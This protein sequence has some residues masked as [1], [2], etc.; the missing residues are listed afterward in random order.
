MCVV[1]GDIWGLYKRKMSR[2]GV[3]IRFS[4]NGT[5]S[6]NRISMR[7]YFKRYNELCALWVV[8][9]DTM[10]L[11]QLIAIYGYRKDIILHNIQDIS[12]ADGNEDN[13]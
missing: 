2:R 12:K 13:I 6:G 1:V 9:V 10:L 8:V 4:R 3:R 11:F 7:R 5:G